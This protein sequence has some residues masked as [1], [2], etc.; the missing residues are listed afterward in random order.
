MV[1]Q[2]LIALQPFK[3]LNGFYLMQEERKR[4]FFP[5]FN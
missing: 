4:L 5:T 3:V 2:A 1:S